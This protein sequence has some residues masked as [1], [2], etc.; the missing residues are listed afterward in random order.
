[1][2]KKKMQV[3]WRAWSYTVYAGETERERE[4]T[5]ELYSRILNLYAI[6]YTCVC[7]MNTFIQV[8]EGLTEVTLYFNAH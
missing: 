4:I 7:S 2:T 5:Q 1:M 6:L 3:S 8:L